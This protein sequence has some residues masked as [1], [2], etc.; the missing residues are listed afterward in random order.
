[1]STSKSPADAA[2]EFEARVNRYGWNYSVRGTIV[3]I[4]KTFTAGDKAAYSDADS[5]AYEI[6][7]LAPL[8][9]GSVWGTDGGSIGG[10]EGLRNGYYRLNKSGS[11]SRFLTALT[12]LKARNLSA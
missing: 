5:E 6:L 2:S 11:G 1:M 12:K 3:T 8:K 9:G 10:A 7:D 4:Q